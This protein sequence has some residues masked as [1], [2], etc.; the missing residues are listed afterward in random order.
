[1]SSASSLAQLYGITSAGAP[2]RG[3]S[4]LQLNQ[5]KALR[6]AAAVAVLMRRHYGAEAEEFVRKQIRQF[7][8]DPLRTKASEAWRRV[9]EALEVPKAP[10]VVRPV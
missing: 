3:R 10:K 4:D 2:G 9:L 5:K 6:D 1:M 7:E 8:K